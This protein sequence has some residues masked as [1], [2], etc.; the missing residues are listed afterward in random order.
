MIQLNYLS[1]GCLFL[2]VLRVSADICEE[3]WQLQI[4]A[5][6]VEVLGDNI[7]AYGKVY[8]P[9]ITFKKTGNK[10]F[11]CPCEDSYCMHRCSSEFKNFYY[12]QNYTLALYFERLCA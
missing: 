3:Q 11:V 2:C 7:T 4:D 5:S 6:K 9:N 1:F 12:P 8:L 10:Y